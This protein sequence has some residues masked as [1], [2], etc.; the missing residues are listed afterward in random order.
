MHPDEYILLIYMYFGASFK[1]ESSGPLASRSM[2]FEVAEI[3]PDQTR[4]EDREVNGVRI[5]IP[6]SE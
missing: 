1:I 4:D 5:S 3:G 6:R 2:P